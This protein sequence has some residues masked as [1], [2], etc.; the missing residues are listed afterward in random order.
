MKNTGL[1]YIVLTLLVAITASSARAQQCIDFQSVPVSQVI[2]IS[3]VSYGAVWHTEAG[4]SFRSRYVDFTASFND[5]SVFVADVAQT[6]FTGADGNSNFT[7]DI[8]VQGNCV[9]ELDFSSVTNV[10]MEIEFDI[11][12]I[13]DD[14]EANPFR[15]NGDVVTSLPAGITYSATA[16]TNGLHVHL[17]GAVSTLEIHGHE[18]ALDNVCVDSGAV[19]PPP[20]PPAPAGCTAYDDTTWLQDILTT[21]TV[22]G[23]PWFTENGIT[24]RTKYLDYDGAGNTGLAAIGDHVAAGYTGSNGSTNFAGHIFYQGNAI[25]ELDFSGVGQPFVEVEFDVN[26][27]YNDTDPNP[28]LV[29]GNP[30]GMLPGALTYNASPL[31]N[32]YHIT[33]SG[34]VT[35]L[36]LWGHELGIDNL[37]VDSIGAS[38]QPPP[39]ASWC[40]D[41]EVAPLFETVPT[42]Q[43][44][45][46]T[47][48]FTE[49][50][51]TYH[52]R[53]QDYDGMMNAGAGVIADHIAAGYTGS[54]GNSNFAGSILYQ[55]N[56]ITLVDFTGL[57]ATFIEVE[58]DVNYI[59]NS[60]EANPFRLNGLPE[61]SLPID[62]TYNATAL[63][64]G[65][66]ITISGPISWLELWGHEVAFDNLCVDSIGSTITPPPPPPP[67][68]AAGCIDFTDTVL[69]ASIPTA[70]VNFGAAWYINGGI[71]FRTKYT[72]FDG[73]LNNG[74]VAI[75]DHVVAG[76]TGSNGSTN[77]AGN[78]FYQG[79]AVTEVD[80]S[81]LSG[82]NHSVEFDVNYI[83]NDG[84]ANPFNVNGQGVG[85]LPSWVTYTVTALTNGFHVTLEGPITTFELA[86]HELALDNLCLQE[87]PSS[88]NPP[89]NAAQLVLAP[90]V[91]GSETVSVPAGAKIFDRNG[92]KVLEPAIDVEWSGIDDMNRLLPIGYYTVYCLDGDVFH[93]TIVR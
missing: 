85:A 83:A 62:V 46:D 41:F 64:N 57:P 77:F 36:E 3:Q 66:H 59:Y 27:L 80:I 53:Y 29:N 31:T 81:G 32:G 54:N 75:A 25:T 93:V 38:V 23:A 17:T 48:W 18:V 44:N 87:V 60:T 84:T 43:V 71:S 22:Y 61:A 33:I 51:V 91:P 39:P 70:Q 13:M 7:D 34:P 6:G 68:T 40:T 63:T 69:S 50:G 67:P 86:G 2:P 90:A 1:T 55:G 79:H 21:Q 47:P 30:V 42:T 15:V 12:Y 82:A 65:Y 19:A 45:Y 8:F 74:S 10:D 20:P 56:S 5:G 92:A 78:I 49:N 14:T 16:L 72:D 35:T 4:V 52:S 28:F 26:Y 58:F 76:Y 24:Y 73:M 89:A 9:T 37:C 88:F 11:N